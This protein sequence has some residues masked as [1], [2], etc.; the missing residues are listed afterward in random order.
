MS[1]DDKENNAMIVNKLESQSLGTPSQ[2]SQLGEGCVYKRNTDDQD[3]AHHDLT[4]YP[5]DNSSSGSIVPISLFSKE[6][7]F[8]YKIGGIRSN[9]DV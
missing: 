5:R 1:E 8:E 3:D 4:P 7:P 9:D 2:T 6:D